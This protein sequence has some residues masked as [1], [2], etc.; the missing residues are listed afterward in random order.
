[1]DQSNQILQLGEIEAERLRTSA[2]ITLET[3][4]AQA[5]VTR[6]QGK[7]LLFQGIGQGATTAISIASG[8]GAFGPGGA[9][10]PPPSGVSGFFS[11]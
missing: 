1:V 4:Q 11:G 10:P 9:T 2:D 3:G 6:L 5:N 7:S 8:F